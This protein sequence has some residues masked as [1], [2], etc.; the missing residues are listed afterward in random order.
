MNL[1]GNVVQIPN[2]TV[3]KSNLRNYTTNCN[4]REMFEIGIGYDDAI[5]ESQ[6]IARRVLD[7]HPAVLQDPEPSVLVESLGQ[8]TV[9]LRVYFWLDGS[10]NSWLK[11][12]SS[13]IRLVKRE[14][15]QH[16][17]SMPDAA[18]EII[19]PQGV[20][21]VRDG[22]GDAAPAPSSRVAPGS[23]VVSTKAEGGLHSEAGVIEEQ[24]RRTRKP[25]EQDLLKSGASP[26]DAVPDEMSVG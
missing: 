20:P 17:I 15:Q 26:A 25:G 23:D 16:G 8:S 2:A 10:K 5:A 11:V 7:A 14:F 21:I 6:E 4:R 22:A 18:R 19:F 3:Y 9:N 24:A 13:V 1:D 12:R